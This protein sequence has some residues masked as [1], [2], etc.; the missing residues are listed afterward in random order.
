M[1]FTSASANKYLNQLNAEKDLIV[2]RERDVA[3]FTAA[4]V[5]KLE[6]VAPKYDFHETQAKL[7]EIEDKI[8]RLKHALN[9]FNTTTVLESFITSNGE[10]LTV[11]SALV[12]MAILSQR[13]SKYERMAKTEAKKSYSYSNGLIV[14]RY[15]NYSV[16]QAKFA[17]ENAQKELH[18]LQLALDKVNNT[19]EF[20]VNLD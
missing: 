9:V 15:A 3:T 16:P 14:Y 8:I 4:T 6:E 18:E 17:Y 20:E 19:V 7:F 10:A 12:Y 2:S 5:E 1:H 13:I 11:D